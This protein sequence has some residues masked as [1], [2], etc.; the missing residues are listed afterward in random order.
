MRV[1]TREDE[2]WLDS[3][4]TSKRKM[5]IVADGLAVKYK[6]RTKDSQDFW[7]HNHLKG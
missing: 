4:Y 6:R 3:K 5:M 7:P 1:A 2:K